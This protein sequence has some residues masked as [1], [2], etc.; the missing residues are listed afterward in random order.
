MT[1]T[2]AS[3]F[4]QASTLPSTSSRSLVQ[5]LPPNELHRI[6]LSHP[7]HPDEILSRLMTDESLRSMATEA[8]VLDN[9]LPLHAACTSW[10]PMSP[11]DLTVIIELIN[12][13]PEALTLVDRD[14]WTALHRACHCANTT[15]PIVKEL[16]ARREKCVYARNRYGDLPLHVASG[17]DS[18]EVVETLL[19]KYSGAAREGNLFG[20]L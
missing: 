5:R 2:T 13:Y 7:H 15:S 10:R 11:S 16:V 9:R 18:V 1:A 12:I 6:L 17:C 3:S 14:G 8:S 4:Q 20:E 19:G